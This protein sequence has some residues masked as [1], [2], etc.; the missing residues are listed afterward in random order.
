[1][2][3][4]AFKPGCPVEAIM[5]VNGHRLTV[6]ESMTVR[7]ALESLASHMSEDGL[8]DDETGKAICAGYIRSVRSIRAKSYNYTDTHHGEPLR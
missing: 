6:A 4:T 8:G 1:M 3:L 2:E 5:T 7:V